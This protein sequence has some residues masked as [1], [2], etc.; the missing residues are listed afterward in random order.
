MKY[1]TQIVIFGFVLGIAAVAANIIYLGINERKEVRKISVWKVELQEF[2]FNSFF[3]VL[4]I[5]FGTVSLVYAIGAACQGYWEEKGASAFSV[6]IMIL[7]IWGFY[8]LHL[9][10][11]H[12]SVLM[13]KYTNRRK[14]LHSIK[15]ETF[16]KIIH[17]CYVS[18][19]WIVIWE[20]FIPKT[21]LIGME[22]YYVRGRYV[23]HYHLK[24]YTI[25]GK[26][27]H[28]K[29]AIIHSVK[30]ANEIIDCIKP[31]A[32]TNHF[33]THF[34][35]PRTGLRGI[36]YKLEGWFLDYIERHNDLDLLNDITFTDEIMEKWKHE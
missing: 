8:F 27:T 18:E 24:I 35:L 6:V 31:F 22:T 21:C 13:G 25:D 34:E 32:T 26:E 29:M 1:E 20:C 36:D 2:F 5:L 3:G 9:L 17:N 11:S 12:P 14:L 7:V 33:L 28:V 15:S 4:G 30:E 19:H 10:I 23:G 16:T